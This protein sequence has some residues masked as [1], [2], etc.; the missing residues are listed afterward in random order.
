MISEGSNLAYSLAGCNALDIV[1][2]LI[3]VRTVHVHRSVSPA[4][5]EHCLALRIM[6]KQS[7]VLQSAV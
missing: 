4:T 7:A 5:D 2:T 1:E 6:P 3:W